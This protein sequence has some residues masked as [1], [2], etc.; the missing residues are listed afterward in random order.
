MSD[1]KEPTYIMEGNY[2]LSW[3]FTKSKKV[4]LYFDKDLNY[5]TGIDE[6]GNH[7]REGEPSEQL[8][9]CLKC[10]KGEQTDLWPP[11]KAWKVK[12]C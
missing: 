6:F 9:I 3:R 11:Y 10:E 12:T 2:A 5:L 7:D 4:T 8:K 1:L